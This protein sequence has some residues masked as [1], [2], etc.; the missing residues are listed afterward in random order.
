VKARACICDGVRCSTKVGERERVEEAGEVDAEEETEDGRLSV[1]WA[2][3]GGGGR[4]G[5]AISC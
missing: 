5:G 1:A 3:I 2:G 4:R